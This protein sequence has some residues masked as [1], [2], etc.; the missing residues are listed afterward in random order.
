MALKLPTLL[1]G[2]ALAV[3]LELSPDEQKDYAVTKKKIIDT[4]QPMSFIS[5]DDFH[6]H[7]LRPEE[8]LS[9]YVHELKQ[10]L[11]QAMLG[12]SAETSEQLLLH[13]FLT[14]LPCKVSKQLCATGATTTLKTAVEQAKIMMTV[15][16]HTP[17]AAAQSQPSNEFH[18]LQQ[19]ISEL[20][21][22]VAA[23]STQQ[24]RPR[25]TSFVAPRSK[26]CFL[27]NKVGHLQYVQHVKIQDFVSH[28]VS[29]AMDGKHVHR[30]MDRGRLPGA[31]VVPVSKPTT[32]HCGHS[33]EQ[34]HSD[35][36]DSGGC[37]C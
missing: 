5:L 37:C 14:G 17:V 24:S 16:Q 33:E 13:Q 10:L 3:W 34:C 11:T 2:E 31:V 9:L 19:Q 25:T 4:I 36:R 27:C 22:Q 6:K 23:L 21:A 28:V 1:E 29:K 26:C 30:E 8:P 32:G 18:Q 7:V 12:I 35:Q 20:T 15:E